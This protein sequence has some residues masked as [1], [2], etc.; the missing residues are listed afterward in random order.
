MDELKWS[1]AEWDAQSKQERAR[2]IAYFVLKGQVNEYHAHPELKRLKVTLADWL[3]YD[4][5]TKRMKLEFARK[6][7]G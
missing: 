4:E 3:D 2:W 1:K 6:D 5:D 7:T